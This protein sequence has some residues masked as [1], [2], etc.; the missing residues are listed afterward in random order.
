MSWLQMSPHVKSSS[1]WSAQQPSALL[2]QSGQLLSALPLRRVQRSQL[3][4]RKSVS[5]RKLRQQLSASGQPLPLQQSGTALEQQQKLPRRQ[6]PQS[7]SVRPPPLLLLLL[8][9][10]AQ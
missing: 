1:R 5:R 6:R 10:S 4:R 7:A 9:A 2:Q 3:Q 8:S